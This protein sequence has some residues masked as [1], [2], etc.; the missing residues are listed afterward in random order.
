MP[1]LSLKGGADTIS[2]NSGQALATASVL[3]SSRSSFSG[4]SAASAKPTRETGGGEGNRQTDRQTDRKTKKKDRERESKRE[5]ER[6]REKERDRR[7]VTLA[8]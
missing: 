2:L 4:D 7:H 6:Y 1:C 3:S 8:E 5:K